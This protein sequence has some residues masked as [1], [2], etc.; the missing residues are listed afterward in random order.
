[1]VPRVLK[2]DLSVYSTWR[3]TS[4]VFP[5]GTLTDITGLKSCKG[6]PEKNKINSYN[7]TTFLSYGWYLTNVNTIPQYNKQSFFF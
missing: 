2:V 5:P 3:G 6:Q 7:S 4:L 1:M